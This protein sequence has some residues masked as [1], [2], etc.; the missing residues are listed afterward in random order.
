ME[1]INFDQMLEMLPKDE[2]PRRVVL[3]GSEGENMLEGLFKA[4]EAGFVRPVLVGDGAR[5][6]EMLEKMG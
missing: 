6:M 5:T 3:A 2:P 4:Q 1:L